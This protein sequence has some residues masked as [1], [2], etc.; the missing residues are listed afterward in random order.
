MDI[1][2]ENQ[3]PTEANRQ[4][5]NKDPRQRTTITSNAKV[6]RL[7]KTYI[8]VFGT[9]KQWWAIVNSTCNHLELEHE[10]NPQFQLLFSVNYN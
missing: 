9:V 8:I 3:T 7:S 2:P 6:G 1:E 10:Q 4:W 5:M